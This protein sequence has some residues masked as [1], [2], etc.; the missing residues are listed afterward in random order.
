M[1]WSRLDSNSFFSGS[2]DPSEFLFSEQHEH[3]FISQYVH[4]YTFSVWNIADIDDR[5]CSGYY[6]EK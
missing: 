4:R 3:R 5:T 6:L 2:L 1:I